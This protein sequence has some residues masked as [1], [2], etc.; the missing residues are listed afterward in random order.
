MSLE[1]LDLPHFIH[2]YHS[3]ILIDDVV[4]PTTVNEKQSGTGSD[5]SVRLQE[6][7]IRMVTEV[8]PRG[9]WVCVVLI[10]PQPRLI[11]PVYAVVCTYCVHIR[12]GLGTFSVRICSFYVRLQNGFNWPHEH[13]GWMNNSKRDYS[14]WMHSFCKI[15]EQRAID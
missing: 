8:L 13:F 6:P 10:R 7:L 3:S 2:E 4:H 14:R 1:K 11:L 5:Q 9:I 15:C 12:F